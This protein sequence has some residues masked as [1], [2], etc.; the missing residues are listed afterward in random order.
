MTLETI[1]KP[2]WNGQI[3]IPQDWR[4]AMWIDKKHVRAK[5]DWMRVIIEPIE[6]EKVEW[7]IKSI[8]LNELNEETIA[9]IKESEKQYR[10]W[11]SD[12]FI[13]H[14]DFWKDV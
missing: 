13:S 12:A 11:N 4:K 2:I 5:F 3:T 10:A 6:T 9:C 1:L 7:D 8:Q 14:D